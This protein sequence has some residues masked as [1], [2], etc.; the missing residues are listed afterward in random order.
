MRRDRLLFDASA[1]LNIIRGSVDPLAVLEGGYLL[2][3]TLYEVG[4]A[5]WKEA[6]LLDG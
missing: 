5:V 3:L 6:K 1:L 4:N 2:D